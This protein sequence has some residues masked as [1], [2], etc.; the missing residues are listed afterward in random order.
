MS[1]QPLELRKGKRRYGGGKFLS[2]LTSVREGNAEVSRT[3][4]TIFKGSFFLLLW[5]PV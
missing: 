2:G 5:T 4:P 1:S 3:A